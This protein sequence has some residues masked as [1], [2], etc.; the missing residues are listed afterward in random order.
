M[1]WQTTQL[2]ASTGVT[3]QSDTLVLYV[4]CA[5]FSVSQVPQLPGARFRCR[6]DAEPMARRLAWTSPSVVAGAR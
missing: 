4:F 1:S 5:L 3:K 6:H 2:S